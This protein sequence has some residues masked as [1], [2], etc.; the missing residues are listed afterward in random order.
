M[1]LL[2]TY[3]CLRNRL[4]SYVVGRSTGVSAKDLMLLREAKK[5]PRKMSLKDL[6]L[7][8]EVSSKDA[9]KTD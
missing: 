3:L 2:A 8:G 6:I 1:F 9:T 4:I 5:S 7:L